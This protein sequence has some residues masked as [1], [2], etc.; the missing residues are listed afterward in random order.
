MLLC[1]NLITGNEK[2]KMEIL[3]CLRHFHPWLMVIWIGIYH[4]KSLPILP[5]SKKNFWDTFLK[6]LMSIWSLRSL[7]FGACKDMFDNLSICEFWARVC[8]SYPCVTKVCIKVLLPF[9]STY[10]CESGFSTLL[11][12]KTKSR[13]RQ[14]AEDC[15]RCAL[16]SISPRIEALVDK[17]QQQVSHWCIF[18]LDIL[19]WYCFCCTL[20]IKDK[21]VSYS[22]FELWKWATGEKRLRTNALEQIWKQYSVKLG[23]IKLDSMF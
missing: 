16:S 22:L 10:L 20:Y 21:L 9:N 13:N 19:L 5:I 14:D 4:L 3:Q 17:F 12:M 6:Y 7:R 23:G 1:K 18:K 15:M 2:S 11:Q 8:I